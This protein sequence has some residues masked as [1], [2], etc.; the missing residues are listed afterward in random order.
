MKGTPIQS[1]KKKAGEGS[2]DPS[3]R[4]K[5]VLM[6][7]RVSN[8]NSDEKKKVNL[9]CHNFP[10]NNNKRKEIKLFAYLTALNRI[11]CPIKISS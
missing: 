10:S 9:E 3:Y 5:L 4:D 2:H 1:R 8:F 6:V 11:L 7:F